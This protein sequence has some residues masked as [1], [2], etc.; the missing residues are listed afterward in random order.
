LWMDS[1]RGLG[2]AK[3]PSPLAIGKHPLEV[4]TFSLVAAGGGEKSPLVKKYVTCSSH[5]VLLHR[6]AMNL[7]GDNVVFFR[8]NASC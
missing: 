5:V 8:I 3:S 2:I 6:C 1:G 7:W 4:F